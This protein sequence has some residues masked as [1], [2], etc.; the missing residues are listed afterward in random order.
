M[1]GQL[2]YED[3]SEGSKIPPLVKHPTIRQFVMWA[4]AAHEFDEPHYDKDYALSIGLPG[5]CAAGHQIFCFLGQLLTDWIGIQGRL[6]KL[7]CSYRGFV[8]PNEDLICK[9]EVTSNYFKDG[10]YFVECNVWAE[11]SKEDKLVLGTASA[12]LPSR[13]R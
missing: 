11:N 9:G 4:A 6:K 7:S 12:T 2:Y 5:V 8:F 10:E 13:E 3:V 1:T